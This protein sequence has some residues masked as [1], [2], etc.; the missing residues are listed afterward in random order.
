MPITGWRPTGRTATRPQKS[1]WTNI[2]TTGVLDNG[3]NYESGIDYA[4][5]G[6]AGRRRMSGGQHR[7]GLQRQQ[8][9]FQFGT[10]ESGTNGWSFQGAMTR[11]SL[12]NTGY[13]SSHS[14]H[15]RAQRQYLDGRQFLSGRIERQHTGRRPDGDAAVQGALAARLAGSV[16]AAEWQLAGSHRRDARA[17]Q[18]RHA[19]HAQQPIRDQCRA[20]HLQRD[21][22]SS[23]AGGQSTGGGDGQCA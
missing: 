11:S 14:L 13:H 21:A 20:G 10:F 3:A 17:G 7:S 18:S 4:Q 6:I 15:I 22:H 8:L 2:E 19:G 1:A 12:E 23:L 5:I 16:V 9:R